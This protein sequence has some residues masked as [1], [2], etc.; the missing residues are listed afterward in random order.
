MGIFFHGPFARLRIILR[1][2]AVGGGEISV[3]RITGA[4]RRSYRRHSRIISRGYRSRTARTVLPFKIDRILFGHACR[5][6]NDISRH[7]FRGYRNLAVYVIVGILAHR[8]QM[9]VRLHAYFRRQIVA[10]NRGDISDVV[11]LVNCGALAAEGQ[12]GNV[13]S[14]VFKPVKRESL[15][16]AGSSRNRFGAKRVSRFVRGLKATDRA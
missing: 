4:R 12:A 1:S 10:R 9:S 16:I 3:E 5:G 15:R 13:C 14:N 2:A 11:L 7:I 8:E 6:D